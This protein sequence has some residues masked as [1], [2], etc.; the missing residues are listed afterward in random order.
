MGRRFRY[1]N[2]RGLYP[3]IKN[4]PAELVDFYFIKPAY[5]MVIFNAFDRVKVLQ[6]FEIHAN[7]LFEKQN[8]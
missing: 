1:A 4:P 7:Y 6:L 5:Y 3:Q 2:S 8:N